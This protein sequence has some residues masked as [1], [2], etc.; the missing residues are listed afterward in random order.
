MS[1]DDVY[2]L[3]ETG[4]AAVIVTPD[5]RRALARELDDRA[6]AHR[7]AASIG[8]LSRERHHAIAEELDAIA[9]DWRTRALRA[10]HPLG[11]TSC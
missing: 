7:R 1:T 10:L 4:H 2:H 9:A 5:I 8:C 6:E 11:G 3:T